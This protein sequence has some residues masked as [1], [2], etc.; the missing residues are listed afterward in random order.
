MYIMKYT[1]CLLLGFTLSHAVFSQKQSSLFFG[2][3]FGFDHGGIGVKAEFQPVKQLGI[4]GGLGYNLVGPGANGGIIFNLLPNKR[5]T[6][7]LTAMYGY[8]AVIKVEYLNGNDHAVY[9]GLTLGGGVDIKLGRRM[10]PHKINVSLMVPL[11]NAEF[12][13]DYNYIRQNGTIKQEMLP[14]GLSVG[15]NYNVFGK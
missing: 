5:V 11:R 9:N 13:R 14:V 4:F 3:G 2:A 7:V 10:N 1:I 6:P 12:F 15:W 8:N